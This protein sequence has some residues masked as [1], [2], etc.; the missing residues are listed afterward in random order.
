MSKLSI[1]LGAGL[2]LALFG[3]SKGQSYA[4]TAATSVSDSSEAA[5]KAAVSAPSAGVVQ[6]TAHRRA[7]SAG[8]ATLAS[9]PAI[10]QRM[11][12]RRAEVAL[13]VDS[14]EKAEKSVG[15]IVGDL[16]GYVDSATSTDLASAKPQLSMTLRVPVEGF[17]VALEQF[18]KLGVRLSKSVASE[19]VTGQVVDLDARLKTLRAQEETYRGIL[20]G[21]RELSSVIELQDKL[22]AVRGEIE[23][24]AAQRKALAGL[25]SLSTVTVKLEQNAVA[26]SVPQDPNWLAQIWGESTT[27]LMG[28]VRVLASLLVWIVVFSPLWVPFVWIV[29][30]ALRSSVVNGSSVPPVQT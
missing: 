16:G 7:A 11:V 15:R 24:M 30:R 14:V 8:A 21:Q 13:R 29:R 19:D 2:A 12:I 5:S 18:E 6:D 1:L 28:A 23:S 27:S 4:E 26:H 3:C 22:T 10:Q 25:A 9:R 20:R 17:D